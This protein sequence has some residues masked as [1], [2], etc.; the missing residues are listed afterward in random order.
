MCLS[1][2]TGGRAASPLPSLVAANSVSARRTDE[3]EEDSL[4]EKVSAKVLRILQPLLGLRDHLLL[5]PYDSGRRDFR[6]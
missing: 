1:L 6:T 4:A 5:Q 2:Q 3:E